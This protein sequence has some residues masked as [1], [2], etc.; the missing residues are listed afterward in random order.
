MLCQVQECRDLRSGSRARTVLQTRL[1]GIWRSSRGTARTRWQ[2]ASTTPCRYTYAAESA[3]YARAAD[4]LIDRLRTDGFEQLRPPK[5]TWGENGYRGINSTWRDPAT[6]HSF[7]V[8]LHTPQSLTAK[9]STHDLYAQQRALPQRNPRGD[10]LERLQE[11]IF[12]GVPQP[13]GARGA[14][15]T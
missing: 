8:Q 13:P 1:P 5:N 2:P 12:A 3:D 11:E 14:G 6:G 7:E 15:R 4:D 9:P 10:E